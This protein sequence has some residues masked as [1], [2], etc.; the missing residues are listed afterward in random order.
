MTN[1]DINDDGALV[2]CYDVYVNGLFGRNRKIKH[3]GFSLAKHLSNK[4]TIAEVH[5]LMEA[6]L[7]AIKLKGSYSFSLVERQ[8]RLKNENGVEIYRTG[9]FTDR[10]TLI[11]GDIVSPKTGVEGF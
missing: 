3:E 2:F 7:K 8:G 1:L 9:L 10:K 11:K 4:L 5:A 6:K